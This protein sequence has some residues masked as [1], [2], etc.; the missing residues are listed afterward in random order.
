MKCGLYN[1]NT[2]FQKSISDK[3]ID[4]FEHAKQHFS[5]CYLMTTLETLSHTENGRK[6]LKD[7]IQ[8]DDKN[9]KLINCYLFNKNGE[10]E[11]Y[12]IPTNA[13]LAGYEKVYKGQENEIIRS[14]DI[15]VDQFEKKH[16]AKPL[17]C[18]IADKFKD[19]SFEKNLPSHFMKTLTGIEP[20]IIAEQDLNI[21]LSGYKEEVMEL[22]ERMDKEKEHSFLIGTGVKMLDGRTWHVYVIQDV[23]LEDNTIT[24]KE[25]RGNKPRKMNIDTALK[26]FKYIVGY[27]DSD[28]KKES[29]MESQQKTLSLY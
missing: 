23:N 22:F 11:K 8:Y 9:P 2:S 14:V 21:D 16:K 13:V 7:Q 3:D 15:S 1:F 5:D 19:Y 17:I 10:Q 24:V 29:K 25:K 6:V 28:L 18:K 4:G 12:T 26:T 20:H 27:F